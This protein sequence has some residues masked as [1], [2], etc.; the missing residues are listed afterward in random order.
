[1]NTR[2]MEAL[3]VAAQCGSINRAAAKLDISAPALKHEL[4]AIE[5]EAGVRVFNR[6]AAGL[7]PTPAGEIVVET[8]RSVLGELGRGLERARSAAGGEAARIRILYTPSQFAEP[9]GVYAQA[10]ARYRETHPGL[11]SR[12]RK[13]AVRGRSGRTNACSAPSTPRY[14]A[15]SRIC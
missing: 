10:L 3:V 6:S 9:P 14:P 7:S 15:P 4:D 12:S 13:P 11:P 1:M 5:E 8:F 2:H